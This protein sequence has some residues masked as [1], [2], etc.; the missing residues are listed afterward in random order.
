MSTM[1]RKA[2]PYCRFGKHR[3]IALYYAPG[4]GGTGM[5]FCEE[6]REK[7]LNSLVGKTG[8]FVLVKVEEV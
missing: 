5:S 2:K 7:F 3:R 4:W 6:C 1:K 8:A